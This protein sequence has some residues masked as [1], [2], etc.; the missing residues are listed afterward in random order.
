MDRLMAR[1]TLCLGVLFFLSVVLFWEPVKL[2]IHFSF[3]YVH[4]SHIFLIPPL[5]LILILWERKRVFSSIGSSYRPGLLLLLVAA[6]L[7]GVASR[8]SFV[9]SQHDYLSVSTL[10]LVLTWLGLFVLFY[11]LRSFRAAAFPLLFLLLMVPVPEVLLWKIISALQEGSAAV[12]HGLFELSGVPTYRDGFLFTLPGL[13]IEVAEECSGIRSSIAL[14][15]T[16]LLAGHLFLRSGWG[17]I[18]LTLSIIPLAILKNGL[19]IVVI[20]LLGIH[21]DQ[22]FLTGYLHHRGGIVFFLLSLSLL[23]IVL[24]MLQRFEKRNRREDG[25]LAQA[26]TKFCP[27]LAWGRRESRSP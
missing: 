1:R 11:G 21:V 15:V 4:F 5:S 12:A 26:L 17:R 23:A 14:F 16:S 7:Y 19:R 6:V 2:L 25:A 9:L 3:Q 18:V 8:N 20:T 10:A 22:G 13:T 24:G 27:W